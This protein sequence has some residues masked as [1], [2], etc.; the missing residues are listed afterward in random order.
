[1]P[2]RLI[3]VFAVVFL[4]LS[5]VKADETDL[6]A[7][8]A[9]L[10]KLAGGFRFTEGPAVAPNGDVYFTDIP[11]NRIHKWDVSEKK[12]STFMENSGGA[13]GLYFASP[14][15]LY[16]CQG[17]EKRIASINIGKDGKPMHVLA[18]A[19]KYN[20]KPF[21]KPNDLW[22]DRKGGIYFTDPNYS[23][24]ALSQD[25]E[26]VYYIGTAKVNNGKKVIRVANDFKRPNGII[27]TADGKTLYIADR[28]ANKT[29]R[30]TIAAAGKL[31][32]KT[33]HCDEGS[34]GMTLDEKGNLYITP[35]ASA[36]HVYSP[37]GKLIAKIKTPKPASNVTFGGKDRKTLFVTSRDGFYAI[38]MAVKGQ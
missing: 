38:E 18:A 12:L 14:N 13:N 30:Y 4:N 6:I 23:R 37:E 29:Y 15:W 1:M 8:G 36:V 24:G 11:N 20:G 27:G 28:G 5:A 3:A 10:I 19:T 35:P 9:K 34:D 26:H 25:G 31:T 33:K 21:N 7:P 17:D 16:A 32:D 2:H 22:I